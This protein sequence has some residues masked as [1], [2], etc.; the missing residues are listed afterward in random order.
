M[1]LTSKTVQPMNFAAG[2]REAIGERRSERLRRATGGAKNKRP[3]NAAILIDAY[4]IRPS[5]NS[6]VRRRHYD[7]DVGRGRI[8][9]IQLRRTLQPHLPR[10]GKALHKQPR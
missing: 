9:F 6:D 10:E 8:T 4:S 1:N 7:S 3:E 5:V 2:H